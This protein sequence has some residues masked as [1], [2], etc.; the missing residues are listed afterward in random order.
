MKNWFAKFRISFA[1]DSGQAMDESLRK[2]IA[3]DA[4]LQNF[5]R[6]TQKLSQFAP[7]HETPP[8]LHHS[9]LAAVRASNRAERSRPSAAIW[10]A[11]ASAAVVGSLA[12]LLSVNQSPPVRLSDESLHEPMALLQMGEQIPADVPSLMLAPMSNELAAVARD[13]QNTKKIL[14]STL[15]F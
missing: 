10:W 9:I 8:G 3:G 13:A 4:E 11:G 14:L 2:K 15:P 7:A 6:Q 1:L 12:L 5:L